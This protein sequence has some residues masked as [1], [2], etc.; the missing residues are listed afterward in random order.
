MNALSPMGAGPLE[1]DPIVKVLPTEGEGSK[2]LKIGSIEALRVGLLRF[3]GLG[4]IHSANFGEDSGLEGP[5]R[6]RANLV[7]PHKDR[8]EVRGMVPRGDVGQLYPV[9]FRHVVDA[10]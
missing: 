7:D 8:V 9:T 5:G 1:R 3:Q 2:E 4:N 10:C 6:R